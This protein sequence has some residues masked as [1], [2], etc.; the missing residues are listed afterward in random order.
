MQMIY[1]KWFQYLPVIEKQKVI[2]M[3]TS[4]SIMK[5]LLKK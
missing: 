2:G 3:V 5:Y 1:K 4:S